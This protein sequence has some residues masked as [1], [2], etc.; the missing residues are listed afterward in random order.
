MSEVKRRAVTSSEW[1]D[2][3]ARDESDEEDH[4]EKVEK[5]N[6]VERLSATCVRPNPRRGLK[7]PAIGKESIPGNG[8]KPFGVTRAPQESGRAAIRF[9]AIR[10][11]AIFILQKLIK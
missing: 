7:H 1:L 8:I 5:T 11:F 4:T 10:V 9:P 2:N 6:E 3:D